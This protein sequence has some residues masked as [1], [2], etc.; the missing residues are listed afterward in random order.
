MASQLERFLSAEFGKAS[1]V[2]LPIV[3]KLIDKNPSE[4]APLLAYVDENE[5]KHRSL[6]AVS[7]NWAEQDA[8]AASEWLG[9]LESGAGKDRAIEGFVRSVSETNPEDGYLWATSM[10]DGARKVDSMVLALE[11]WMKVDSG[12]AKAAVENSGLSEEMRRRILGD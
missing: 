12:K 4:A 10:G 2:A 1:N 8:A 11:H 6:S 7:H 9:T 3:K 5:E